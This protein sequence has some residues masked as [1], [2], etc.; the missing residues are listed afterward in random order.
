MENAPEGESFDQVAKESEKVI[1]MS[2]V[3]LKTI[4]RGSF[5]FK[6]TL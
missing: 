1:M 5:T 6:K 4:P 3:N 2:E